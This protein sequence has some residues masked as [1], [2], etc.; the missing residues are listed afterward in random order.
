MPDPTDDIASI[1]AQADRPRRA[2]IWGALAVAVGF[3]LGGWSW[4]AAR[5]KASAITYETAA[6]TRGDVI[7]TVTA[8]GS[9][10]PR[11]QVDISSELSGSLATVEVDYNDRV[12]VG[13]VLARLDDTKL[14]SQVL[15]AEAQLGAARASLAQAQ[16]ADREASAYYD[17]QSEL[18][19]RGQS[20]RLSLVTQ[21]AA[22]DKARAAVAAATAEVAL[23][24]AHLAESRADLERTVIRSPIDG[25]VLDRA[26][27]PGQIVASS[28]NAPVLF[29]LAE[30]LARMELQVDVDEADIGRIAVGNPATFTVDAYPGRSFPATIAAVRYAPETVDGVVTFKA[31]LAVDNADGVLRPGM[32]ATSTI[33]VAVVADTLMIPDAAVRFEPP[34]EAVSGGGGGNGLIGIIMPPRQQQDRSAAPQGQD[35]TVWLLRDGIA[36]EVA[37]K[38]GESDGKMTAVSGEDLA[39][40]DEVIID[41]RSDS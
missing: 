4:Y 33:S 35:E 12:T 7:V 5:M 29:T 16:A 38:I 17:A 9:V 10:Q 13:Q 25:V 21:E 28:L 2:W 20:S 32:T 40:G 36:S 37:V 26:A 19:K 41:Q 39:E 3:G 31:I 27:E 34:Q 22:R 6:V 14:R 1:L 23:A 15:T 18:D 24:E 8:T 30:D 11:T